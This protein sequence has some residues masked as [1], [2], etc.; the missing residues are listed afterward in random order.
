MNPAYWHVSYLI[1]KEVMATGFYVYIPAVIFVIGYFS[2]WVRKSK[3]TKVLIL[4]LLFALA[5]NIF[6]SRRWACARNFY[7]SSYMV[8]AVFITEC[9]ISAWKENIV[10]NRRFTLAVIFSGFFLALAF[11]SLYLVF[12]N[13]FGKLQLLTAQEREEFKKIRELIY[14]S[15]KPVFVEP[16]YFALPWNANQ[17]PTDIV[18]DSEYQILKW[19]GMKFTLEEKVRARYFKEAF[20]FINKDWIGLFESLGYKKIAVMRDIVYLRR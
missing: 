2:G 12:P 9:L 18:N 14:F 11:T 15:Q 16:T 3:A 19:K 8:A 6:I 17:Y 5:G 7:F 10:K 20:V 1:A 13:R 4:I